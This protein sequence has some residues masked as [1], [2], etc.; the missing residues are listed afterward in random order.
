LT[1]SP[2]SL[3]HL[4]K[5]AA[6]NN[7]LFAMNLSA[8]FLVE[9]FKDQ[10]LSVLPYLDF[11]FGNE[12]ECSLFGKV[13]GCPSEDL[14]DIARFICQFPKI[15]G[16]PRI[17]VITSG[18]DPTI[19]VNNDCPSAGMT[20]PV[21]TLDQELIVDTNAAGDAFCGGYL[22]GLLKGLNVADCVKHGHYAA[23]NVIQRP[24]C[25]FDFTNEI[26]IN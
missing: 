5:H 1:V 10:M 21:P 9:F 19:V 16:Q 7:K 18:C 3:I 4:G 26:N 23:R 15:G 12:A 13:H 24:G 14:M 22:Y 6:E 11:V 20:F 17:V 8:P 2:A 25:S